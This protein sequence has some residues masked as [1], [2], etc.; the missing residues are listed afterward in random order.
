MKVKKIEEMDYYEILNVSQSASQQEI[1]HAYQISKHTYSH[2]SMALH[3]M[4]EED[5]RKNI[6]EKIEEAYKVLGTPRKRKD[7]DQTV[8]NI[9]SHPDEDSYFRTST[10]KMIIE[11]GDKKPGIFA[12]LKRFIKKKES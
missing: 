4:V 5:E 1:K 3:S 8:L 9:P 2:G 12:F 11:D 10:N 7:Y 6:L